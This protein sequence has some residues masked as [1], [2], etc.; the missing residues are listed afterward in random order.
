[1]LGRYRYKYGLTM[2]SQLLLLCFFLLLLFFMDYQEEKKQKLAEEEKLKADMEN[3]DAKKKQLE[4][5]RR[6]SLIRIN[7]IHNIY[8]LLN[9]LV[10]C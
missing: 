1:M 6:V 4:L 10:V 8:I 7:I 3:E 9:I 2:D 5:I